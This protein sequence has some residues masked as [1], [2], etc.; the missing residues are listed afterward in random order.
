MEIT[1]AKKGTDDYLMDVCDYI[2]SDLV[3]EKTELFKAYNY[4]NGVRDHYQYENIEKNYGIGNPTSVGFTPLTRKHIEAIV[5]EYMS[6]K[7]HP[8]ISCKDERTLTNINRDKQ[9]EIA[10]R[11]KEYISGYLENAIYNIIMSQGELSQSPDKTRL[12]DQEIAREIKNIQDTVNRNFISNYEIA[13][14]DIIEYTLQN[15]EIDFYNKVEQLILDLLIAGQAYYKVLPTKAMTNYKLEVCDPLNSWIDK[16]PK[17]RYM[18]N[19]YKA[20]VRKWMT[21]EEIEIKY[22]DYLTKKDLDKLRDW[23]NNYNE[24]DNAQY[25]LITGQSARCG[26]SGSGRPGIW[27][28][29][30]VHPFD[31]EVQGNWDLIPV[32][33]VEWIDSS[34]EDGKWIGYTYHVTRIGQDL[35]VLDAD[36]VMPARNIDAPNEARLSINGIWYTNGHGAPYS[37]MLATADLQDQ[38]DLTIYKK[39]NTI[40]LSGTKGAI[41]NMPNIPSFLGDKPEDRLTKFLGYRKVGISMIDTAQEGLASDPNTIYGG[42]DDT[43]SLPAMQG[44][45]ISLQMIEETVSSI[46]GVFRERLGGIQQRDA[47]ANVEVGMQQSYII[48]KRYYNAM[49]TLVREIL[50]D[51]IDMAKVVFKNGLTGQLI[52]GDVKQ[53]FTLLPE[54]YTFTSFDVD[55]GDSAQIIKEQETIKQIAT[56]YMQSNM[57]DPEIL[58]IIQTAKSLTEMKDLALKS[59]REKKIENDQL[60][61]LQQQL[62]QAQ[63]QQKQMQKQLEESTR[64]IAQL[65]ERKMQLDQANMQMDQEIEYAKIKSNE[66][67]K[68]R[69][70][71][72]IEQR[73]RLEAAQLVDTNPNNDEVKDHRY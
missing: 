15:R 36:D 26:V 20:V 11:V 55:M 35:Y 18:K 5:G 22:G 63:E 33:E 62:E 8:K 31:D 70:L 72:L 1:K 4:F 41:V 48:T 64:K 21:V 66:D 14:Q 61:Q 65:N 23:K 24:G 50:S 58:F 30:E 49:D 37:L 38:Y 54:Y 25:M 68:N 67:I 52:L 3:K 43:L 19:G 47:V 46:T 40:A 60:K 57:M 34:K 39:D 7:P 44:F 10:K 59:I 73:N 28:D 69:E 45:Q 12:Q 29:T 9:L 53:I 13:A 27:A 51:C 32:Y 17:S 42:F 56:N 6:M 2:I 16:D 71:D